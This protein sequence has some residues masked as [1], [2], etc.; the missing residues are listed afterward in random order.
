MIGGLLLGSQYEN[1]LVHHPS[2]QECDS[3][4]TLRVQQLPQVEVKEQ[5]Y[6][7]DKNHSP[8][9]HIRV[10][11]VIFDL[12]VSIGITQALRLVVH[13][14]IDLHVQFF[15][16]TVIAPHGDPPHDQP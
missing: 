2:L 6:E 16:V 7:N 14:L 13:D 4:F 1:L 10:Q 3:R 15:V 12:L 5:D 11:L 8:L 9:K